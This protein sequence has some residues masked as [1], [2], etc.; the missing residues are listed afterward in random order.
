MHVKIL[1]QQLARLE[2]TKQRACLYNLITKINNLTGISVHN[3]KKQFFQ[4]FFKLFLTLA[5]IWKLD[6]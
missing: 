3:F 4:A 6:V 2:F 5:Y 1:Y